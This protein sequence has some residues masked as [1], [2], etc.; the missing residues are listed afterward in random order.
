MERSTQI[1]HDLVS[2]MLNND[3]ERLPG[4]IF[5]SLFLSGQMGQKCQ[6]S[7]SSRRGV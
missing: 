3:E 5:Q 7:L 2:M 1:A 6:S 4:G